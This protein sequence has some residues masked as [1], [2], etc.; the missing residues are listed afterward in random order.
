MART[1]ASPSSGPARRRA[2]SA[3]LALTVVYVAFVLTEPG[4]RADAWAFGFAQ[5]LGAGPVDQLL[6]WVAR[7]ALPVLGLVVVAGLG[8]RALLRGRWGA[9]VAGA[10][11]VV[12]PTVISPV[13]REQVLWRPVFA[14]AHAYPHNTFP[15]THVALVIGTLTAGRLLLDKPRRWRAVAWAVVVVT[16]LGNVVGHAHRPSDTVGGVLLVCVVAGVVGDLVGRGS[17]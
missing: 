1:V 10:V 2:V 9:V 14:A 4:Q 7:R 11:I 17:R 12:L 5:R 8:V 15:S 16:V 3:A 13:L 6:P